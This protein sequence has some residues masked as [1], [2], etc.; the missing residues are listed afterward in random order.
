MPPPAP[1]KRASSFIAL[2]VAIDGIGH[3]FT[4]G[5]SVSV[6]HL[7]ERRKD[8][9]GWR[10]IGGC[11]H[12]FPVNSQ[13]KFVVV[14]GNVFDVED[15]VAAFGGGLDI[16][17]VLPPVVVWLRFLIIM[18]G[19]QAV[20]LAQHGVPLIF[21]NVHGPILARADDVL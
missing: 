5:V 2:P 20:K 1:A 13:S 14:R 12:G 16:G 3:D 9:E 15:K 21:G 18:K 17:G 4:D 11:P 6:N 10:F 8:A 7:F 19:N